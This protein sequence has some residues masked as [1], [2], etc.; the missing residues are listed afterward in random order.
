MRPY[1]E[2]LRERVAA[3]VDAEEGSRRRLARRFRVSVSFITRLLRRRRQTGSLSP[4]PHGGGRPPALDEQGLQRLRELLQEQ[5]D[6]TLE[7]LAGRLGGCSRMAVLRALRKLKIT[8]KKK[9]LRADQRDRPD[10]QQKRQQF[11]QEVAGLD[12]RKLVFVDEMGAHTAMTRAYGRA[13]RGQRVYGSVPGRWESM[14][15]ITGVRL[16][17]VVAPFAFAG[18]TDTAAFQT[19]AEDVLATQL[20]KGDVVIWD[21]LKP[22][23]DAEAIEAVGRAGARVLAAPPWSPDLVP[24]EKMFSKV[25]GILRTAAARAKDALVDALADALRRVRPKDILGWFRSCGL[26]A[27]RKRRASQATQALRQRGPPPD[28]CATQT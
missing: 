13:P 14:T 3:A 4:R 20:R 26:A 25:K 10:V 22:H 8:R 12:P 23:K 18:A 11:Q 15:L 19:Y 28:L 21:N 9:T 27:K 24:I 7:E 6:A 2:D 5:P 16:G 17:G 1:S